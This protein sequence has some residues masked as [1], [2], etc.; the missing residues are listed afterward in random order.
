M[1]RLLSGSTTQIFT[2]GVVGAG[3]TKFMADFP[4]P[5]AADEKSGEQDDLDDLRRSAC[6]IA[7]L[8]ADLAPGEA[9][10]PISGRPGQNDANSARTTPSQSAPTRSPRDNA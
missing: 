3:G 7:G 6:D 9:R 2:H 5:S 8:A 4:T 10:Q 1:H